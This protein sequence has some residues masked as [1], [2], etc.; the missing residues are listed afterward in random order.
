MTQQVNYIFDE[1][2]NTSLHTISSISDEHT[3]NS[4]WDI[5]DIYINDNEIYISDISDN[6]EDE[7]DSPNPPN[8]S[9]NTSI[10]V[11]LHLHPWQDSSYNFIPIT[12]QQQLEKKLH[13]LHTPDY[14]STKYIDEQ[15]QFIE[16]SRR[17]IQCNDHKTK[18]YLDYLF[19]SNYC[20][21]GFKMWND[22][23]TNTDLLMLKFV[24]EFNDECMK[25]AI[26]VRNCQAI[27]LLKNN[28]IRMSDDDMEADDGIQYF[29]WHHLLIQVLNNQ[30]LQKLGANTADAPKVDTNDVSNIDVFKSICEPEH[31]LNYAAIP[32]IFIETE[33]EAYKHNWV[34]VLLTAVNNNNIEVIEYLCE[35]INHIPTSIMVCALNQNLIEITHILFKHSLKCDHV[36]NRTITELPSHITTQCVYYPDM[37]ARQGLDSTTT[38]SPSEILLP[39]PSCNDDVVSYMEKA[40]GHLECSAMIFLQRQ[41]YNL[42]RGNVIHEYIK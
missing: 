28:Q 13:R 7:E 22:V 41:L 19:N 2:S 25:A 37:L 3:T 1:R 26:D 10:S 18:Q 5:K 14:T 33:N 32:N 34:H 30:L 12:A 6:E 31:Y 40:N 20:C 15:Q 16:E 21:N 35:H 8:N 39:Q 38:L 11:N 42:S 27:Y 9:T 24:R 29:N 17:T 36:Y 23:N 4:F